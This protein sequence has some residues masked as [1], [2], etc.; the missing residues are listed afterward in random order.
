MTRRI[1]EQIERF[2]PGFQDC[3]SSRHIMQPAD[4]EKHNPNL[5]GGSISGGATDIA[6]LV[7]RPILSLNPYRTPL[8]RVCLLHLLLRAPACTGCAVSTRRRGLCRT[9]YRKIGVNLPIHDDGI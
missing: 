9:C 1:E 6:Q 5:I 2:A 8:T 3:V 7:A 4:L